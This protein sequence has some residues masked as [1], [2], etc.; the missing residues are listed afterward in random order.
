MTWPSCSCAMCGRPSS[1]WTACRARCRTRTSPAA[2]T[3]E[4]R[5]ND[6]GGEAGNDVD[7][8]RDDHHVEEEGHEG[9]PEHRHPDVGRLQ[10]RVRHLEGHPDGETE[11]GEV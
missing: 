11:V 8:D 1:G 5:W 7:G 3:T 10:R 2:S 4:R 9:V 6:L